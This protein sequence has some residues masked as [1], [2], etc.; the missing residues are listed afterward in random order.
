MTRCV[1]VKSPQLPPGRFNVAGIIWTTARWA[2]FRAGSRLVKSESDMVEGVTSV[3]QVEG[4]CGYVVVG[5]RGVN[6]RYS[7]LYQ[8]GRSR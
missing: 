3:G 7:V 5:H 4:V 1:D 2:I 8:L 6:E